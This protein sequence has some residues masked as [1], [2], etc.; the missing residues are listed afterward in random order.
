M[1]GRHG[2]PL[3]TYRLRQAHAKVPSGRSPATHPTSPF[4]STSHSGAVPGS[5]TIHVLRPMIDQK[6][7][8][9]FQPTSTFLLSPRGNA[10][11][12]SRMTQTWSLLDCRNGWRGLMRLVG[13]M[14][15][16]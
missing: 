8:D 12:I 2:P 16:Y 1:L 10:D 7:H 6:R 3:L 15:M 13:D 14:L 11:R 4:H 9:T 5:A